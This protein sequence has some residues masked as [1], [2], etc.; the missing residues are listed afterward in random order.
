MTNITY[1]QFKSWCEYWKISINDGYKALCFASSII[2]QNTTNY[3][4]YADKVC[5]DES[6]SD[7]FKSLV[8]TWK[9]R[10][11]N[12]SLSYS[13]L[14]SSIFNMLQEYDEESNQ[15]DKSNGN[16]SMFT[17]NDFNV[18][19]TDDNGH[20]VRIEELNK[21]I[22]HGVISI[23]NDKLEEYKK[24]LESKTVNNTEVQL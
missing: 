23:D 9:E 5:N 2:K 4:N 19:L 14:N 21:M 10:S 16:N 3:F 22:E 20:F 7:D 13:E 8:E 18:I 24:K 15:N 11:L 6:H 17:V 12:L 1:E